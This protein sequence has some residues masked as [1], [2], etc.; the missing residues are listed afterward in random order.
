MGKQTLRCELFCLGL[1]HRNPSLASSPF[2]TGCQ[3]AYYLGLQPFV[4]H[5]VEGLAI[6]MHCAL[7]VLTLKKAKGS[8]RNVHIVILQREEE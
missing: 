7:T 5:R 1:F 3:H 4:L 2:F 8:F 6:K